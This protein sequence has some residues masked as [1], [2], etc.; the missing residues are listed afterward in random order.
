MCRA[1]ATHILFRRNDII[2]C[3]G[4]TSV[5][6]AEPHVGVKRIFRVDSIE[7]A[8]RAGAESSYSTAE[9]GESKPVL[10]EASIRTRM[11]SYTLTSPADGR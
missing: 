11:E 1:D 8:R 10:L 3:C 4:S 2:G 9:G 6:L 7:A 5:E